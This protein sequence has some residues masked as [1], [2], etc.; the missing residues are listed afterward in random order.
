MNIQ[1]K[2]EKLTFEVGFFHGEKKRVI[3][4]A[5]VILWA[6]EEYT[7]FKILHFSSKYL[8]KSSP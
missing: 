5:R 8:E 6:L 2:I 3:L 1:K 4:G 7:K